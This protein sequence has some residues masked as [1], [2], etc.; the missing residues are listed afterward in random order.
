ML[1]NIVVTL[2]ADR[3]LVDLPQWLFNNLSKCQIAM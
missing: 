2:Y 3:W 1:D